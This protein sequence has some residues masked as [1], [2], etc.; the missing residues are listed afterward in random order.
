MRDREA[1]QTMCGDRNGFWRRFACLATLLPG[2]LSAQATT[3]A[4][5]QRPR[6]GAP[7][8][9]VVVTAQRRAQAVADEEVMNRVEAA[10]R[11]D[12]YFYDEHVV[13]TVKNGV[14][15]LHGIVFDDWDLRQAM[16]LARKIAGVKRVVD[17]LEI[18]VGGE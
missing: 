4:D 9:T 17:D 13:V 14:A 6:S 11:A 16:R 12:A 15:T 2:V 7:L 3:G 8:D 1:S 5:P 10:L 18:K